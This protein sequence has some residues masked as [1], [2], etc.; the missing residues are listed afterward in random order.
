MACLLRQCFLFPKTQQ[1]LAALR[2]FDNSFLL[3]NQSFCCVVFWLPI[4]AWMIWCRRVKV[5][6]F[7][8]PDI[9]I[10]FNLFA[11]TLHAAIGFSWKLEKSCM[12]SLQL[13]KDTLPG[14]ADGVRISEGRS[15]IHDTNL[16]LFMDLPALLGHMPDS[17]CWRGQER[18]WVGKGWCKSWGR[19]IW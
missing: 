17:T 5:W 12:K 9:Y 4:I 3:R 16:P 8:S 11:F 2:F 6:G 10:F 18:S 19:W 14:P 15:H 13:G 7:C 1:T